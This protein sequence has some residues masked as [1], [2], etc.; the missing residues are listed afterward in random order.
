M[1]RANGGLLHS[2]GGTNISLYG[3]TIL[4]FLIFALLSIASLTANA[5]TIAE[6]LTILS[7][8][9]DV[10]S[11]SPEV[12]RMQTALTRGLTVCTFKTEEQLANAVWAITKKIRSEGAQAESTEVLEGVNAIL[13]G[14]KE[15]QDCSEL[16]A[17]YAVNRIQGST[18]S[19]AVAGARGIYRL[20]GTVE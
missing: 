19:D 18:H 1:S 8:D 17:L 16:L 15:R 10:P 5:A 11:G 9:K 3:E 4:K 12:L 6:K 13:L 2:Q 20:A 14:A 7:L